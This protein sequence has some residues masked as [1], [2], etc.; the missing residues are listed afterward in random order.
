[1]KYDVYTDGACSGNPGAGGYAFLILSQDEEPLVVSGHRPQTTNNHMELMAIVRGL[2][3]ITKRQGKKKSIEI[4]IH[5]DSA[6]C[7]NSITFGWLNFWANNNWQTK[8]GEEVKNRELW[9]KYLEIV[10]NHPRLKLDFVKVK[11]HSGDE[12]NELVDRA[13]KAAVRKT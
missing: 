1:M 13:A 2:R 12:Y 6:Y 4:T 11:G 10:N 3:Y 8:G 7:I 5:S 9:E